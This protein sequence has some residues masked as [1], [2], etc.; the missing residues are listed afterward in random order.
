MGKLQS[1]DPMTT[2]F[3]TFSIICYLNFYLQN[4]SFSRNHGFIDCTSK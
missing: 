4:F 1:G 3:N 2:W